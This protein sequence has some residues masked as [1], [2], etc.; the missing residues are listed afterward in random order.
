[1]R[2]RRWGR[3]I[4]LT[5][6]TVKQ[7]EPGLILSNAI[8][9][10][11]GATGDNTIALSLAELEHTAV[12]ALGDVTFNDYLSSMVGDIGSR[13][14]EAQDLDSTQAMVLLQVENMRQSISGV[15]LDEEAAELVM[16]QRAFQA[17]AQVVDTMDSM[18]ETVIMAIAN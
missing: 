5:S 7:P 10:G 17:A 15:S 3:V 9:A 8:R 12:S 2:T 14:R 16:A 6:L 4:F 18:I 11:V 1:M 13:T